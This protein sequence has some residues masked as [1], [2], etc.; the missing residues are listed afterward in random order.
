MVGIFALYA[1]ETGY[2][3]EEEMALL[4][5]MAG[6]ISFAMDH[7]KKE[8]LINYLAFFNAVTDLPN[9]AL[10]LDRVDQ[11]ISTMHHDQRCFQ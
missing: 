8:E 6:D 2:F 10:F 11:R 1:S 3:D 9:R 4:T 7:L 5:E